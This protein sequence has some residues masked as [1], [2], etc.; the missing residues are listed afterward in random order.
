MRKR[1][2]KNDLDIIIEYVEAQAD[3]VD[4]DGV[5]DCG[6][7]DYSVCSDCAE[8]AQRV[9]LVLKSHGCPSG[10]AD[11]A[12]SIYAQSAAEAIYCRYCVQTGHQ[13]R[14]LTL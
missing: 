11:G 14:G 3:H 8:S 1:F 9:S 10:Y 12:L 6:C 2:S 5:A 7:D 4:I 13:P